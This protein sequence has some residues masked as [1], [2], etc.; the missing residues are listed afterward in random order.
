MPNTYPAERRLA[1]SIAAHESWAA[2]EDRSARTA[3]ARRALDAK[4]LEQAGG[5][6]KRAE[7]LRSAYFKRLALKSA[8][9]RRRAREAT[10]AAAAAEAELRA[11]GGGC[12]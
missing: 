10:E 3:P 7:S 4:F 8:Q 11:I 9:S 5:D 2:T 6:P 12:Q 1:A